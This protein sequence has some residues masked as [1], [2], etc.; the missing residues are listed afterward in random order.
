VSIPLLQLVKGLSL[1][2]LARTLIGAMT[3]TSVADPRSSLRR[4]PGPASRCCSF[5]RST[6]GAERDRG[7]LRHRRRRGT[8]RRRCGHLRHRGLGDSIKTFCFTTFLLFYYDRVGLS[9]TLLGLAMAIGL[10]WDAVVDPFIDTRPSRHHPVRASA[11][12]MLVGALFTGAGVVAVFNPP[13][14]MSQG[15]SLRGSWWRACACGRATAL[16]RRTSSGP[17]WP[18]MHERTTLSGYRAGAV[19]VGTLLVTAAAFLIFLPE[20][21]PGGADSKFRPAA[22]GRW[23]GLRPGDL[24]AGSWR[25]S[26]RCER[27]RLVAAPSSCPRTPAFE[28]TRGALGHRSSASLHVRRHLVH[29]HHHQRGLML[30]S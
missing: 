1:S 23:G 18:P 26:A 10:V 22:T 24:V 7:G 25:P 27:F 20:A 21:V 3:G 2:E 14:G 17:N 5:S 15:R 9:G 28:A 29:G 30:H 8:T 19:L 16:R 11:R 13:A 6:S 12:F 4:P